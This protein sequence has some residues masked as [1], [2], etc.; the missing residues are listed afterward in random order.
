M[1]YFEA[2]SR[3]VFKHFPNAK[4]LLILGNVFPRGQLWGKKVTAGELLRGFSP[5]IKNSLTGIKLPLSQSQDRWLL[6]NI[7]NCVLTQPR[8]FR[9]RR[10]GRIYPELLPCRLRGI[11][12]IKILPRKRRGSR[13][14]MLLIESKGRI[15]GTLAGLSHRKLHTRV[16]HHRHICVPD[17]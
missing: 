9:V 6:F 4:K 11:S 12:L 10:V 3:A 7:Q 15:K 17:S 14:I 16:F 5:R 8:I 2:K 13:I 1:R